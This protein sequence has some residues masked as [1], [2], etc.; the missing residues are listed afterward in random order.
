MEYYNKT[1]KYIYPKRG[2]IYEADLGKTEGS[3]QGGIRPVLIVQNDTGNHYAPTI[4]CV[5]LTSKVK[6]EIPTHFNINKEEYEFLMY[7]STVLCEQ[8]RTLSKQRLIRKL[9]MLSAVDMG[10]VRERLVISM[11]L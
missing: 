3:E 7:D 8:I 5:P 11:A 6:R 4:I 9:G 1:L 2:E 10:Y